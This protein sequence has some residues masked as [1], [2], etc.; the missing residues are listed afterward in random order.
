M[1]TVTTLLSAPDLEANIPKTISEENIQDYLAFIYRP[2][3]QLGVF[4]FCEFRG[5]KSPIIGKTSCKELTEGF[6]TLY[7]QQTTRIHKLE[8]DCLPISSVFDLCRTQTGRELLDILAGRLNTNS[9]F[10]NTISHTTF[11]D[12]K[13]LNQVAEKPQKYILAEINLHH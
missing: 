12:E 4:S 11:I 3:M 9:I 5:T 7:N 13:I 10:Y 1:I 8:Q 2:Y 6:Q